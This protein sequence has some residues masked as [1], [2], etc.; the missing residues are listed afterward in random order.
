MSVLKLESP[1][2]L[3]IVMQR[4]SD[5]N[6]S[7]KFSNALTGKTLILTIRDSNSESGAVVLSQSVTTFSTG[8]VAD[9]TA[10]FARSAQDMAQLSAG[11]YFYTVQ[12]QSSATRIA[13]RLKGI[14]TVKPTAGVNLI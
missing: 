10:I 5:L 9:D 2:E 3:D 14:F 13:T 1:D 12:E 4:G 8:D 11:N 6:L 7:L